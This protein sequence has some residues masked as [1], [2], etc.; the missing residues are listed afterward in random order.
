M[1]TIYVQ[2]KRVKDERNSEV[3]KF[4]ASH[5]S[6]RASEKELAITA[7]ALEARDDV[8]KLKEHLDRVELEGERKE[9]AKGRHLTF[10]EGQVGEMREARRAEMIREVENQEMK[11][12]EEGDALEGVAVRGW[13]IIDSQKER[14][15]LAKKVEGILGGLSGEA[16][17]VAADASGI[18]I[19][20]KERVKADPRAD[21][22]R[23][24]MNWG[25]G[26]H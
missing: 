6:I 7:K 17:V 26:E 18:R 3:D 19:R 10:W 4:I 12:K 25:E 20:R 1:I 8:K 21:R 24:S 16:E 23:M 13:K 15:M 14:G 5:R 9:A 11:K 22:E 2:M